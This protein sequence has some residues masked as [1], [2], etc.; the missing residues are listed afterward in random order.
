MRDDDVVGRRKKAALLL[1]LKASVEALGDDKSAKE[2]AT[3]KE[4]LMI[5][6]LIWSPEL[7]MMNLFDS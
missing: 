5:D 1:L 7:Q 4:N 6:R 3:K 2:A